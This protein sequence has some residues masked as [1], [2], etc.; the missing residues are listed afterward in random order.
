MMNK[1]FTLTEVIV[2]AAIMLA[3]GVAVANFTIETSALNRSTSQRLTTQFEGRRALLR[4]IRE[5]RQASM[6][7]STSSQSVIFSA[8][9][10]NDGISESVRFYADGPALKRES[11]GGV[12]TL[13]N[14]LDASTP[15][16]V[17]SGDFVTITVRTGGKEH[18]TGVT[19]R[20][21]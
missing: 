7:N 3:L 11:S 4:I 8:D 15:L 9:L 19:L 13:V 18:S 12:I 17:W 10:N 5:L 21:Q 1:G 16:F 14:N 2:A 6:L 20:N